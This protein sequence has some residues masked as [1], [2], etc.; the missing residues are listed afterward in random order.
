M[1]VLSPRIGRRVVL[2]DD[3]EASKPIR[4]LIAD[5]DEA[6]LACYRESLEA[7]GFRVRTATNA[8]AFL[9]KLRRWRPDAIVLEP[10]LPGGASRRAVRALRRCAEVPP[11]PVLIH[12][13]ERKPHTRLVFPVCGY[14]VRPLHPEQLASR[15][16]E[17]LRRFKGVSAREG[18][19]TSD[20]RAKAV[21]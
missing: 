1:L 19:Q 14:E 15:V 4:V 7:E 6:L 13:P 3:G 2:P 12:S 21:R 9:T 20:F 16:R 17:I 5:H 11:T 10:Y 8:V 18:R